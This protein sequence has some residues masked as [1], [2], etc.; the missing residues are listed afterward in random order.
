LLVLAGAVVLHLQPP[1]ELVELGAFPVVVAVVAALLLLL[2][3]L[4]LAAL[5]ARVS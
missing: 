4:A 1:Q 3:P 5:V 2:E